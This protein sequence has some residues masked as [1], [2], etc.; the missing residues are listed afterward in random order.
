MMF[1]W[2]IFRSVSPAPGNPNFSNSSMKRVRP[3]SVL[4]TAPPFLQ[5]NNIAELSQMPLDVVWILCCWFLYTINSSLLIIEDDIEVDPDI[6]Q[7]KDLFT[8]HLFKYLRKEARSKG[9]SV[10]KEYIACQVCCILKLIM[11]WYL[12]T[13]IYYS[14]RL[15]RCGYHIIIIILIL[16]YWKTF[17]QI[18]KWHDAQTLV[19]LIS[20][21][22]LICRFSSPDNSVTS[23]GIFEV[24]CYLTQI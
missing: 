24:L 4:G 6:L 2:S 17:K 19:T 18:C 16:S 21:I 23:C 7:T 15:N 13:C 1:V 9:Q 8:S 12:N 22:S 3:D 10:A 11:P 5:G 14:V 20:L